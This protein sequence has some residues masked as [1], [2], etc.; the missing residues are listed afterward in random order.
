MKMAPIREI[1]NLRRDPWRHTQF[2]APQWW[3]SIRLSHGVRVKSISTSLPNSNNMNNHSISRLKIFTHLRISTL[4]MPPSMIPKLIRRIGRNLHRAKCSSH[5]LKTLMKHNSSFTRLTTETKNSWKTR[6]NV[7][8]NHGSWLP[9]INN[10]PARLKIIT[11][12]PQQVSFKSKAKRVTTVNNSLHLC[13]N[14]QIK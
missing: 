1:S 14:F 2:L 4:L 12:P 9:N 6:G 13:G 7:N 11:Q 10:R 3:P 5:P 8:F